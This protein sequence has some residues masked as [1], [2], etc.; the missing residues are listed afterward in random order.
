[1]N[2]QSESSRCSDAQEWQRWRNAGELFG[3]VKTGLGFGELA[4]YDDGEFFAGFT[5]QWSFKAKGQRYVRTHSV[6]V[7]DLVVCVSLEAYANHIV[8]L[9]KKTKARD[10]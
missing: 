6:T 8:V 9:M 10:R 1:M 3:R 5:L 7:H 2:K 4:L